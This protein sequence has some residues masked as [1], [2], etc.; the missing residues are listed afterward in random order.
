MASARAPTRP[1]IQTIKR[2]FAVSGNR[3]AFPKCRTKIV[4]GDILTG[5]ICHIKGRRRGA[6]RYD[7]K[8]T[9]LARHS[10]QNL[11]LMCSSHHTLVDADT[12]SYSVEV[13][14]NMKARHEG[15][16][17]G[18]SSE[19]NERAARLLARRPVGSVNQH[20][21][22]TADTINITVHEAAQ[23]NFAVRDRFD[24]LKSRVLYVGLRNNLPVELHAL[25]EFLVESGLM[26]M[27][28]FRDFFDKWLTKTA[29]VV[30]LSG[31]NAFTSE[32]VEALRR[33][34]IA[35]RA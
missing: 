33:D 31:L 11:L 20:G 8:Q 5:E 23:P 16:W 21:G 7:P 28:A 12:E 34:L 24:V 29:V 10:Y 19:L 3:C 22:I 13:L 35:L 25:R 32:E 26:Q 2:L 6:P 17:R 27:P 9:P 15:Q 18:A 30:G 4:Q 1:T 14:R